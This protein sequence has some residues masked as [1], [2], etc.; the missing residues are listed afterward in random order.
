MANTT[1]N[2]TTRTS[3]TKQSQRKNTK[4]KKKNSLN[5]KKILTLAGIAG[6]AAV[7]IACMGTKED[8]SNTNITNTPIPTQEVQFTPTVE[9]TFI[10]SPTES[11]SFT[12]TSEPQA[13]ATPQPTETPQATQTPT[14]TPTPAVDVEQALKLVKDKIDAKYNV[15]LI[16]DHLR[17]G[18]HEY[19]QFGVIE[20]QEFLYPFFV[21]D[22]FEEIVYFYDS[23]D[24][25]VFDFTK[26]PIVQQTTPTPTPTKVEKKEL[27]A[28]EAYEVLCTYSK[29]SLKIAKNVTEYNAEYGDELTLID[30]NQCYRVN[31]SEIS[32]GKVR[33]RGE[34][35]IS[36]DGTKCYYI[37]SDT[38]EFILAQK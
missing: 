6:V 20:N 23:S 30:G 5:S 21:V 35:Y 1:R 22:K 34:F 17:L 2:N 12:P 24:Q 14:P 36:I 19:Y 32:G 26:F 13:T 4:K 15:Q 7:T 38:N 25:T 11:V 27:T 28:K 37:D 16:N 10:V 29:E 3:K 9:P 33:N 8:T 31:L 18:N